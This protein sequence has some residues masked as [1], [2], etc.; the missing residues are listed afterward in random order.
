M[1]DNL[2][3]NLGFYIYLRINLTLNIL[4]YIYNNISILIIK[5]DYFLIR[6]NTIF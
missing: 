2:P 4:V 5:N 1:L 3:I 6:I